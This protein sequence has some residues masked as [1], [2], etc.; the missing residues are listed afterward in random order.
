MKFKR[1]YIIL[2][3]IAFILIIPFI[4][5]QYTKEV[6]W[7]SLDFIAASA[8]LLSSGVAFELLWQKFNTTK[9]R[10]IVTACLLILLLIVW[11]E[12]AVGIF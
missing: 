11:V 6:R 1:F 4:A 2:V 10:I 12:L 9:I 3:I 5:M 8:L 7:T